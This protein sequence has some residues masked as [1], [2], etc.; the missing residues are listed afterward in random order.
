[1]C[2]SCAWKEL[3]RVTCLV[4][5]VR[6]VCRAVMAELICLSKWRSLKTW[7]FSRKACKCNEKMDLRTGQEQ[8]AGAEAEVEAAHY[9][10]IF[11]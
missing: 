4:G 2:G 10:L 9:V 7:A 5:K 11:S 8:T 6:T 1:M 3:S